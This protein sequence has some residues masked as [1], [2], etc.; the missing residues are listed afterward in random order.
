[1]AEPNLVYIISIVNY[2][3]HF[4]RFATLSKEKSLELFDVV[5]KEL[6]EE[7]NDMIAHCIEDDRPEYVEGYTKERDQLIAMNPGDDVHGDRPSIEV[8]SLS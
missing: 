6:I 4:T 5:R 7:C 3:T 2:D 1:M 8:I